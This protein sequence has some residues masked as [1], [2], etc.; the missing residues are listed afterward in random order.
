MSY[1]PLDTAIFEDK[2]IRRLRATFG[3]DGIAFYIYILCKAYGDKGYY[4]PYNSDFVL[5]AA[6]DIGCTPQKIGLMVDY[7]LHSS[8]LDSTRYST[9]KVLTSHGIQSQYQRSKRSAKQRIEIDPALWILSESETEGFVECAQNKI[10]PELTPLIPGSKRQSK[11][12]ENK[13]KENKVKEIKEKET[14]REARRSLGQYNWVKLTDA[15]YEALKAELGEAELARCIKYVDE[16]AQG[17]H[18]RNGWKDWALVLR[19]CSRDR[20]GLPPLPDASRNRVVTRAEYEARPAQPIS[21]D[22]LND[23][24]EKI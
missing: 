4:V 19:K 17:T 23:I 8:L 24:L 18:N 7:L 21:I 11:I 1:F 13:I 6:E 12:K 16:S 15:E 9:V 20:W 5:D 14:A 22:E 2:R 3:A 10:I